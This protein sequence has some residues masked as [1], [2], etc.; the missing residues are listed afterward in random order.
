MPCSSPWPPLGLPGLGNFVA[1]FLVL[2]GLFSVQP[3]LAAAASLGLV[4]AAVY[5]LW[6][7]QQAFQGAP[8]TRRNMAD[9][10]GREMLAMAAMMF[11]LLWLGLH[12]QPVLDLAQPVLDSL[13]A[14]APFDNPSPRW[15]LRRQQRS[16]GVGYERSRLPGPAAFSCSPPAHPADGTDSLASQSGADRRPRRDH[17]GAGRPVLPLCGGVAPLQVTPLL[18]ADRFALLFCTLF[19]F[20]GAITAVLSRDYVSHHGDEAGGVLPVAGTGDH[21]RLRT[22]LRGAWPPCCWVW[23][24][25]RSHSMP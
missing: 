2:L 7:M 6:M 3:W 18:L 15:I 8:D 9:F 11:A 19:G 10:D 1:E 25:C 12:P 14:A 22:G 20:A 13:R 5:S 4:T 16:R 17:A 24:C 23:S 21:G